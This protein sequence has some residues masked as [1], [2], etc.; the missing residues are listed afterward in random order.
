MAFAFEMAQVCG[1]GR[2]HKGS[3]AEEKAEGS[4]GTRECV[5]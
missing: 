4:Q 5:V 3:P 1:G 2:A